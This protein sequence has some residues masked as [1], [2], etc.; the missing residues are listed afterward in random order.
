M[1]VVIFGLFVI[2]FGVVVFVVMA[3]GTTAAQRKREVDRQEREEAEI[4]NAEEE[5]KL[6]SIPGEPLICLGCQKRFPGP[7]PEDGCPDCEIASLVVA[8]R[9]GKNGNKT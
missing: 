6:L 2:F 5:L 3:A 7:M 1:F 8:E 9:S 4:R